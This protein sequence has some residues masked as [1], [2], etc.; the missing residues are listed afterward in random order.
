MGGTDERRWGRPQMPRLSFFCGTCKVMP[1]PS[2]RRVRTMLQTRC[3]RKHSLP[4]GTIREAWKRGTNAKRKGPYETGLHKCCL[5]R[6]T[7]F[8][9]ATSTLARLHSTTELLPHGGDIQIRTGD[10]GVAVHCLTTW[11]C[12]HIIYTIIV[13]LVPYF[14]NNF[15]TK[16]YLSNLY[17]VQYYSYL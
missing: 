9:P 3:R 17:I 4:D 2:R 5:E 16:V 1:R 8:E 13:Y 11:L 14:C 10:Q 12:R 6:E 15:F 7:G